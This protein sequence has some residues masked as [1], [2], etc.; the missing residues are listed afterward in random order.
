[1]AVDANF[2]HEPRGQLARLDCLTIRALQLCA[3]TPNVMIME[4][5][6]G[7]CEGYYRE[8]VAEVVPVQG[9]QAVLTGF[10]AGLGVSLRP[11]FLA[12]PDVVR[13]I[14]GS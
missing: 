7:F 8:V 4:T 13:R 10:G 5:V 1:M 11:E 14:S 9:G 2:E 3:A 12:R 6:R